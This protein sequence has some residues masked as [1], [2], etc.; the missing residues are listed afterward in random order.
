MTSRRFRWPPR[1]SVGNLLML[2]VI[3]SVCLAW[4]AGQRRLRDQAH[5]LAREL[6]QQAQVIEAQRREMARLTVGNILRS[7]MTDEQKADA[8][9]PFLKLRDSR[10]MIETWAGRTIRWW[11]K[12]SPGFTQVSYGDCGLVVEYYPNNLACSFGYEM[13]AYG[14]GTEVYT[15]LVSDA[16][17]TWPMGIQQDSVESPR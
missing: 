4:Y 12:R 3:A 16:P 8:L 9:K 14:K 10:E 7:D 5:A 6:D 17:I 15:P 2:M 11:T 1:F 13:P